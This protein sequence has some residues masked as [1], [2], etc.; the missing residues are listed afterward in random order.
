VAL[1]IGDMTIATTRRSRRSN[2]RL[3]KY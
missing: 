2:A 3:Q 1:A